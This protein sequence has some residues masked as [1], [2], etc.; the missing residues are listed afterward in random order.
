MSGIMVSNANRPQFRHPNEP[1]SPPS[2]ALA[3]LT[4]LVLERRSRHDIARPGRGAGIGHLALA[5]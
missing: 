3:S 1:V 5:A 2:G 4:S